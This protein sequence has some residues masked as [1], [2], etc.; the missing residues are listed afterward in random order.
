MCVLTTSSANPP[1][2]STILF[3]LP[4]F[5]QSCRPTHYTPQLASDRKE[6]RT[7]GR[8]EEAELKDRVESLG[9][10]MRKSSSIPPPIHAL[11]FIDQLAGVSS[12]TA[13]ETRITHPP[14]HAPCTKAANTPPSRLFIPP[15]SS[16]VISQLLLKI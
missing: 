2:T 1:G 11:H 10:K 8:R 4:L 12:H 15:R 16:S 5:F 6:G 7:E 3:M 13:V 9:V 14:T